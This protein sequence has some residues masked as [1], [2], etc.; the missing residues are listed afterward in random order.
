MCFSIRLATRAFVLRGPFTPTARK[1]PRSA[2]LREPL[3]RRGV[4]NPDWEDEM[5]FTSARGRWDSKKGDKRRAQ[6]LWS[7]EMAV[8]IRQKKHKYCHLGEV[9]REGPP[10]M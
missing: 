5:G 1:S 10:G 8:L 7:V 2:S 3:V 6:K 9:G 4:A